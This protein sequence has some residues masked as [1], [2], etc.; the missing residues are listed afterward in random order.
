MTN[1]N[2]G[3]LAIIISA[4]GFAIMSAF[5]KLSG[6][7]PTVQK[8][9]FRNFVSMIIAF[10]LVKKYSSSLFGKK[11]NQKYL[12]LRSVLGLLGI[13]LYFYAI[14][15]LILSD[16]EMLN[17]SSP[18]LA[19]ILCAIFLKEKIKPAQGLSLI[20]AFIGCLFI[21]K[22]QFNVDIF[23]FAVGF[24]SALFAAGAYTVLRVLGDKEK[25]YT[26]VFYFSFFSTVV[27]AP[28]MLYSYESMRI[29]QLIYL[30]L[31]GIFASAGQFGITIAYRLAPAKEISIFSYFTIVFSGIFS[32]V[33]FNQIPD[34]LSVLGYIIIFLSSLYMYIYNNRS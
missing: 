8:A 32:I 28:F 2:K 30:L 31:A 18:F 21:I 20:I 15:N 16:A 7:L 4:L 22:P 27:L 23:P 33:L 19:I 25:Y 13:V 11:E 29:E 10:Y 6:D 1:R 3:I 12:V 5:V 17:K 34:Y 24:M 26:V 9:F 14:D